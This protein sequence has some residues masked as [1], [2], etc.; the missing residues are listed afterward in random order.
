MLTHNNNLKFYETR[1]KKKI[2]ERR[3]ISLKELSDHSSDFDCWTAV[4]GIVYN[5][6]SFV[7]MHPG[8]RKILR[9]AGKDATDIFCKF[10]Y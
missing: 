1:L 10:N 7:S 2:E 8:G 3:I 5:V 9:G 6:T 4:D